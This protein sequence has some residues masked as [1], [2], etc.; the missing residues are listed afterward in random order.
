MK[1]DTACACINGRYCYE[2]GSPVRCWIRDGKPDPMSTPDPMSVEQT[3]YA[4][5]RVTALL[6]AE[7]ADTIESRVRAARGDVRCL[8]CNLR[9]EE[10]Q[11]YGCHESGRGHSYDEDDLAAAEQAE[12]S[13]TVEYVTLSVADLRAA[14]G[15]GA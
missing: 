15:G 7:I 13:G 3:G 6:D 1:L 5:D 14:L 9:Y 11:E 12:R 4:R 10:R 2:N 8:D